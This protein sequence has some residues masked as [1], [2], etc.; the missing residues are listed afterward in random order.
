MLG[1]VLPRP[2][3]SQLP[4]V[5]LR[6][7]FA[8]GQLTARSLAKPVA[9]TVVAHGLQLVQGNLFVRSINDART[10]GPAG[11]KAAPLVGAL[12]VTGIALGAQYARRQAWRA[13]ALDVREK[14]RGALIEAVA[15]QDLAFFDDH[16]TGK[17]QSLI[18]EDTQR[19]GDLIEQLPDQLI[20]KTMTAL[21]AGITLLRLSPKFGV[22]GLMPLPLLMAPSLLLGPMMARRFA[23]SGAMRGDYGQAIDSVIAGITDV[24]LLQAEASVAAR[25]RAAGAGLSAA[26]RDSFA[27]ATAVGLLTQAI[28]AGTMA[29]VAAHGGGLVRAGRI[30][31]DDFARILYLYP[32]LLGAVGDVQ[33]LIGTYQEAAEAAGRIH[34]V[35]E[36]RPA[37]TSGPE[38]LTGG[39]VGG[40]LAIEKVSFGYA[41]ERAVL[42]DVSFEVGRGE[43]VAIVGRTG[44]GKSTL[45]RLIA[46]LYEVG[47]GRISLD[48][49]DLRDLDLADLRTAVALVSQETYLFEGTIR[50]NLRYGDPA[51]SDDALRDALAQVDAAD[52]LE[53]LPGG[54]DAPVGE[55]GGR[56]SGGE[57]QRVAIARTLLRK[58]PILLL[59][60]ITSHL[61]YETEESI[62]QAVDRIARDRTLVVV[63]H[64]LATICDATRI[65][66]LDAGAVAETGTHREL[67]ALNGIYAKLWRL[68]TGANAPAEPAAAP[69][70]EPQAATPSRRRDAPQAPAGEQAKP[71]ARPRAPRKPKA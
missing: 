60:E 25:L 16:G 50:D 14:L 41:S 21:Y 32:M 10:G 39:A 62:R 13:T 58:A 71:P 9:L 24:K 33:Q 20:E 53:R 66:V 69:P 29:L 31:S 54:L 65:V 67:L 27:S 63:T 12:G 70:A 23:R 22:T 38:R 15:A 64:R 7:M 48:G 47:G 11:G 5:A 17:L 26:A 61:D 43:M 44:S 36:R 57:R 18:T 37:I 4:H 3:G 40:R 6:Q 56:L 59:D 55:R 19:I 2:S 35:L 34:A 42:R 49:H 1:A 52:L 8:A 30:G 68:Q 45:L 46:R 28:G 51:A